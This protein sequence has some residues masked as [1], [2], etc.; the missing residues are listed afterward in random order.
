GLLE[1]KETGISIERFES[2]YRI[3]GF[4]ALDKTLFLVNP[5]YE[6]KFRLKPRRQVKVIKAIPWVRNYFTTCAYYL[7]KVK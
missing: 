6:V 1:I 2:I 7:L 5:N 3:N 4:K